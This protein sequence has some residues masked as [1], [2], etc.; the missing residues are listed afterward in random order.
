MTLFLSSSGGLNC[1]NHIKKIGKG[2]KQLHIS[3]WD[4]DYDTLHVKKSLKMFGE[5]GVVFPLYFNSTGDI[6]GNIN[7]LE[8]SNIFDTLV[9]YGGNT[10]TIIDKIKSFKL[11][12]YIKKYAEEKV[13]VGISAGVDVAKIFNLCPQINSNVHWDIYEED[14]IR[15][16]NYI[17]QESPENK[18][19]PIKEYINNTKG[20]YY[21][22]FDDGY[23]VYKNKNFVPYGK[24]YYRHNGIWYLINDKSII[25]INCPI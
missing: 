11:L 2:K 6:R 16:Q 8:N 25:E 10:K 15:Y 9:M 14:P 21:L 4:L 13:Y 19:P 1:I 18:K 20:D 7:I 17:F 3:L 12:P 24:M 22:I 23:F 5:I